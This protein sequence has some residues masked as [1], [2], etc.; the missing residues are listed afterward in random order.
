MRKNL[1]KNKKKQKIY[2]D[3]PLNEKWVSKALIQKFS[4]SIVRLKCCRCSSD[5]SLDVLKQ[6]FKTGL[7]YCGWCYELSVGLLFDMDKLLAINP[8]TKRKMDSLFAFY[9]KTVKDD[10]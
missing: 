3:K 2:W 1:R 10:K 8:E 9:A 7:W 5:F 4:M 6:D